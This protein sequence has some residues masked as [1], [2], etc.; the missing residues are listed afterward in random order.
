MYT[1]DWVVSSCGE[2]LF[3]GEGFE[4]GDEVFIFLLSEAS[5]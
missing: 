5:V 2:V 3:A 1:S 4:L